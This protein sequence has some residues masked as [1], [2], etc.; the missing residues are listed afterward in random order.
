MCGITGI[1][2]LDKNIFDELFESLYHLQ[3]R[4]Q[5]SYG[6]AVI[7]DIEKSKKI[8]IPKN[9]IEIVKNKGLLLNREITPVKGNIG[10]GHVRYP[11]NG[12]NTIEEAQPFI[13]KGFYHNIILVHNGQVWKTKNLIDYFRKNRIFHNTKTDSHLILNLLS[14]ELNKYKKLDNSIICEIIRHIM[15]VMEGSFSCICIIQNY[16]LI[17]FKDIKGIR[18]LILGIKN[19]RYLISS[20]SVS[21]TSLDYKIIKDVYND[22][23]IFKKNELGYCCYRNDLKYFSPC[24]FEWIYLAR[25]ESVICNVPVYLAR[26]KMGESL[27]NKIK[28]EID[29]S[30]ID[31]IIPVPE[32]SKP[33]TLS[34]SKILGI[35]YVEAIVKNRYINRTFIMDTQNKRKK[36]IKRKLNVVKNL[37]ENMNIII[38]D[39]SIVRGNTIKHIIQL[40]KKN[41]VKKIY[42]VSCSPKILFENRYG[43]DIPH[44]EELISYNKTIKEMENYYGVEKILFHD[45]EKIISSIREFNPKIKNFETSIFIGE[46]PKFP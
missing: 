31:Y 3:H 44:R 30:N 8:D 38:V 27:A 39:D 13:K 45:L 6:I 7:K 24:I 46:T 36:N 14:F 37:I 32:T 22:I 16:G 20:E 25:E 21:L 23:L 29:I 40:L 15:V 10:I 35:P 43:I 17:V 4:G 41:G 9:R 19:K 1:F 26:M 2:S 33:A 28:N 11:T 18:P 5:D 42:V 12:Q 34:I